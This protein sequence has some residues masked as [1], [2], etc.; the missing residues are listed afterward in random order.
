ME[1]K[2]RQLRR[3]PL[4][5]RRRLR[6]LQRLRNLLRR[7]AS[8]SPR[9]GPMRLLRAQLGAKA[10]AEPVGERVVT[11]EQ[12]AAPDAVPAERSGP[13]MPVSR[14]RPRPTAAYGL[15]F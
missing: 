13:L 7:R 11:T 4:R 12:L 3:R 15:V 5:Y 6:H 14:P 2:R 8:R 10:L 1:N 9:T